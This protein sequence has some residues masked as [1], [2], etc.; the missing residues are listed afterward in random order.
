MT[1]LQKADEN[2]EEEERGLEG[3]LRLPRNFQDGVVWLMSVSSSFMAHHHGFRTKMRS[4][5]DMMNQNHKLIYCE[6]SSSIS[7]S[8]YQVMQH[9][10][11]QSLNSPRPGMIIHQ[12]AA[13][14]T[15]SCACN[16][17]TQ[18]PLRLRSGRVSVWPIFLRLLK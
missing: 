4:A 3:E 1:S 18:C 17:N 10:A 14:F 5:D 2:G 12:D 13:D 11:G 9:G 16:A 6:A 8:L 15:P 7:Y